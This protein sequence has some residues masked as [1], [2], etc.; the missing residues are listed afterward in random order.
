V[1]Q[2]PTFWLKAD[3]ELNICEPTNWLAH[4][5][6]CMACQPSAQMRCVGTCTKARRENRKAM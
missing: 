2:L 3:A 6:A 5:I 1:F 4:S